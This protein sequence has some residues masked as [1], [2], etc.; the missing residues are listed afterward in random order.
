[1][2][3][4]TCTTRGDTSTSTAS[5]PASGS[6]P[7]RAFDRVLGRSA[8]GGDRG[9]WMPR[10]E[11]ARARRS[12][13]CST[14][15]ARRTGGRESD[16]VD[17]WRAR[18]RA[19]AQRSTALVGRLHARS[20][21]RR[22]DRRTRTIPRRAGLPAVE[23]RL[24]G[25]LALG[26]VVGAHQGGAERLGGPADRRARA[27]RERRPPRAPPRTDR[28]R[29]ATSCVEFFAAPDQ[30]RSARRG[31]AT[32][33]QGG[34]PMSGYRPGDAVG[35]VEHEEVVCTRRPS[36]TGRSSCSTASPR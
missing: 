26:R 6:S 3:R 21:V 16:V 1:M 20:R 10:A 23:G 22:A 5:S 32:A 35:I 19:R 7:M 15:R 17:R 11:R 2:R 33:A 28:R 36:P 13:S 34:A 12:C 14:R 30:R 27:A 31:T 18:R 24:R 29:G 4:P 9:R 25:R 8:P